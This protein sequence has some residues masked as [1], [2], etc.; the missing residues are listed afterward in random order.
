MLVSVKRKC[1]SGTANGALMTGFSMVQR[2]VMGSD[3]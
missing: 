1:R 2:R 3:P